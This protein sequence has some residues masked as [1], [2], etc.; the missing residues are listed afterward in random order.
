MPGPPDIKLDIVNPIQKPGMKKPWWAPVGQI[1]L[2]QDTN[3]GVWTGTCIINF[4]GKEY[5]VFEAK[6]KAVDATN[7]HAT[8]DTHDS[9]NAAKD[10]F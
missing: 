4:A 6:P 1:S 2:W 5:R 3:T 8:G 9:L 10:R 7:E